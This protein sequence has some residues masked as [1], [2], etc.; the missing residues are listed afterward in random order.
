MIPGLEFDNVTFRYPERDDLALRGVSFR[1]D[2]RETVAVV[3]PSGAGKSAL[4]A[5]ALRFFDPGG[6]EIRLAGRALSDLPLAEVHSMISVVSPDTYLF[7]GSLRD[8]IAFG[9]PDAGEAGI[10]EAVAAAGLAEF[11]DGLP[12]GLATPIGDR[13]VRLSGGQR[14]RI[15]IARALLK[16]APTL[17][18]DEATSRLDA[19]TESA[20]QE[21]LDRVAGDRTTLVIARRLSTVRNADRVVI[22]EHGEVVEQGTPAELL[23]RD[24]AY[25]GPVRTRGAVCAK[26]FSD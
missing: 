26:S 21:A 22:L 1:I 24:G 2:P 18:L 20:V 6:G 25:G 15:G 23:E 8:N 19:D 13:G 16:D 5:L 12:D 10:E 3:G 9:R 17:L 4:V 11:V 7:Y 14:R